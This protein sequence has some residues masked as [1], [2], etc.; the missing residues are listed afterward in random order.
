MLVSAIVIAITYAAFSIITR[1]YHSFDNKH[2]DMAAVLRLDELLQKDFKHAEIVLKDTDG[3]VLKDSSSI[4][5]YRF[6]PD[7]VLR[8]GIAIDTFKVR[9]DSISTSF[10]NKT[11]TEIGSSEEENRLDDLGLNITL[12]NEKIPYHYHKLY[13]SA[14]LINRLPNAVN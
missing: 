1:S 4:I 12:Q 7:Y 11:I 2:K 6:S 8:V 9:V 14:N 10:E 13:S 3:I 5:K